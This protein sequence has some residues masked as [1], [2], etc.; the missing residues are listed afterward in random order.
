[1]DHE[2]KVKLMWCA[3]ALASWLLVMDFVG[4][5]RYFSKP[6]TL[7]PPLGFSGGTIV[8]GMVL[9][10]FVVGFALYQIR[11]RLIGGYLR[12]LAITGYS[13]VA[14][15]IVCELCFR[16]VI[17][18]PHV[19]ATE[20]GFQH[21]ISS[22]WPHKIPI[23]KTPGTFRIIGLADS[24]GRAGEHENYHYQL[25]RMLID[26]GL[27]VE[28]VNFSLGPME[29]LEELA[30]LK[31]FG[32]KYQPNL[33]LHGFYVGNDFGIPRVPRM[34]FQSCFFQHKRG[35][36]SLR[37][38]NFLLAWWLD[39]RT[40]VAK[41]NEAKQEEKD[42]GIAPGTFSEHNFLRIEGDILK[43][44]LREPD[45]VQKEDWKR[46]LDILDSIRQ[47]A[48]AMGAKYV[49]VIHP[50]QAQVEPAL[51]RKVVE[52]YSLSWDRDYDVERPQSFLKQWCVSRHVPCIDLL[53]IFSA[54][55]RQ[56]VLYLPRD[57]HY[58]STGNNVAAQAIYRFLLDN[59]LVN[60]SAR[61]RRTAGDNYQGFDSKW[62]SSH[63]NDNP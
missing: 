23:K 45:H 57:T 1:M 47:E 11:P 49:M 31:R 12:L 19:P 10:A 50:N 6:P 30:L 8:L 17:C 33:V 29:P 40:T 14:A 61:V 63:K 36:P 22:S 5:F 3:V 56:G 37:P 39:Q 15:L 4:L 9:G 52:R 42:K 41:D 2:S 24:F 43:I 35:F 38:G 25:E 7:L 59:G 58:N 20:S 32:A 16:Y 48:A 62:L 27:K 51:L 13:I 18:E 53:P 60:N 44:C 26:H 34:T 54:A 55:G 28:V 46:T 21:R